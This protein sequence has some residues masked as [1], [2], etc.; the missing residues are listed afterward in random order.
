M[1]RMLL[2][3]CAALTLGVRSSGVL[4][5]IVVLPLCV[6]A[7]IFGATA[8][9]AGPLGP[10]AQTMLDIDNPTLDFVALAKGMGVPARNVSTADEF[11]AALAAGLASGDVGLADGVQQAGLACAAGTRDPNEHG[12]AL[13]GSVHRLQDLLNKILAA[14]ERGLAL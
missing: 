3:L 5:I 9:G 7:I 14:H 10:K 12:V 4:L 13:M 11:N 6:P 1:K 8:V 2:A